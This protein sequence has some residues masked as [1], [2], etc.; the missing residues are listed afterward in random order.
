MR[1]RH[2]ERYMVDYN[3]PT[4]F[5]DEGFMPETVKFNGNNVTLISQQITGTVDPRRLHFAAT[6]NPPVAILW[7][8][9]V[10]KI[11]LKN[12]RDNLVFLALLNS[13]FMDWYFR[14]TSTNNHVQGYEL[15]QL[16]IP[17]MSESHRQELRNLATQ[18]MEFKCSSLDTETTKIEKK[19]DLIVYSLYNLGPE[20]IA[21]VEANTV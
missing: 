21:I 8:N 4:E 5:F 11:L 7:G 1:G 19:I 10:N 13:R 15:E 6:V 9:S 17:E 14:V 2:V 18:V 20:E 3:A 16:P 12:P